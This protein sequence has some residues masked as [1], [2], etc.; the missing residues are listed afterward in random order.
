MSS[1]VGAAID[2]W[3]AWAVFVERFTARFFAGDLL[4]FDTA[5]RG[6]LPTAPA[7]SP[8]TAEGVLSASLFAV[9]C[10]LGTTFTIRVSD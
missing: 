3:P 9:L 2:V 4:G 1:S 5:R 10:F 7:S 6:G 8:I